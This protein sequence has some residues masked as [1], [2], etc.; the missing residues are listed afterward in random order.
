MEN[1]R[2]GEGCRCNNTPLFHT[3]VNFKGVA[4]SLATKNSSRHTVVEESN[5]GYKLLGEAKLSRDPP[6]CCTID[7]V[8]RFSQIDEGIIEWLTLLSAFLL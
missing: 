8:K 5:D 7:R 6:K 1:G 4:S 2:F 3:S